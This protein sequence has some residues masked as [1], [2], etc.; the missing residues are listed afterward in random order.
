M[1]CAIK[2]QCPGGVAVPAPSAQNSAIC[3]CSAV[4]V[5]E[6][7]S[8]SASTSWKA[9]VYA[10][11]STAGGPAGRNI[12]PDGSTSGVTAGHCGNVGLEL[13]PGGVG[14]QTPTPEPTV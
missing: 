8:P 7:A 4:R 9:E 13:N 14:C 12:D 3:V 10:A 2:F 11:L 5:V 1:S 6:S